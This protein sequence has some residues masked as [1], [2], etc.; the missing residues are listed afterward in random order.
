MI[1]LSL[2]NI[3]EIKRKNRISRE[4]ADNANKFNLHFTNCGNMGDQSKTFSNLEDM[5][6]KLHELQESGIIDSN[7]KRL[8]WF[9]DFI[10]SAFNIHQMPRK[11]VNELADFYITYKNFNDMYDNVKGGL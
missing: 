5:R 4:A 6:S 2:S 9:N 1:Y 3:E 10:N 8:Q 11:S 7:D